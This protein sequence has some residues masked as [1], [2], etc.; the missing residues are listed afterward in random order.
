VDGLGRLI[1]GNV[2]TASIAIFNNAA[3]ATGNIAP[4]AQIVG[5]STGLSVPDQI[6]VDRTGNGTLYN[7]DPG[8]ARIAIYGNLSTANGNL[9][10]TRTISGASTT[11]T[12]AGQPVG[13]AID[14][15]R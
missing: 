8:A 4:S 11:L 5:T 10:P 3:T 15:T 1:V 2:T 13:V 9:A 7:A 12:V 14:T 6:V